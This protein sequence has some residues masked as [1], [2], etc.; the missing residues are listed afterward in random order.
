MSMINRSIQF[1]LVLL[2][3]GAATEFYAQD[4]KL[5]FEKLTLLESKARDVVEVN[6]D[7]KLL[8][9]AKRVTQKLNDQDARTVGQAI[10]GLRGIYV[11][12][13]NF[14]EPNQYNMADVDEIRTELNNPA[15]QKVANVRS[16]KNDQKVDIY[17]MFT[18][19]QM[20]G[21]A[22]VISDN[23]TVALVNVVGIIDIDTLVEL[24][25]KMNIP[26]VDIDRDTKTPAK[27]NN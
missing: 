6:V 24:S 23:K 21:A 12:V 11:R 14:A 1:V 15:W 17:T 20:S 18:G 8:D 19:D 5:H 13:Y 3:L 10:S 16:K 7:G 25:G 9:L 2:V 27:P 26:K 4:A 22:V